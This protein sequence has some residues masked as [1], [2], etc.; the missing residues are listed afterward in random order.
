MSDLTRA[1]LTFVL[2]SLS[3]TR[4]AFEDYR[5]PTYEL[6]R[7]RLAEVEAVTAKVRVLR[8]SL[9]RDPTTQDTDGDDR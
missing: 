1:D 8:N 9:P 6:R 5:Y 2:E 7:E 4:R 3:F